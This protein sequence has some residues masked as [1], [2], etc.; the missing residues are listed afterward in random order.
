MFNLGLV[1]YSPS[2][3]AD[4]L[5]DADGDL[6]HEHEEELHEVEGAVASTHTKK[7]KKMIKKYS[8]L[9]TKLF[10]LLHYD[11]HVI[12]IFGLKAFKPHRV[13]EVIP[14][15]APQALHHL[16]FFMNTQAHNFQVYSKPVMVKLFAM[17][18]D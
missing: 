4:A 16:L 15:H 11:I 5:D 6:G 7:K 12:Y 1:P 18:N 2:R 14:T 9:H 3:D 13:I 17:K 8:H 10:I